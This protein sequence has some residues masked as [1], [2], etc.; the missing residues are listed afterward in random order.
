[1]KTD[2]AEEIDISPHPRL[3]QVLLLSETKKKLEKQ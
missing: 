2:S 1:M 3:S